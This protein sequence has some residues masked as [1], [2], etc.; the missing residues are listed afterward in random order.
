MCA[1]VGHHV[2][3][4]VRVRIGPVTDRS[5]PPGSWRALTADEVRG[6]E[7]SVAKVRSLRRAAK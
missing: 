7:E 2:V 6:L 1:A 4:L 5:L 3:R